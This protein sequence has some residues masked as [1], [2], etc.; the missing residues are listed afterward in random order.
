MIALV[1]VKAPDVAV[2]VLVQVLETFAAV[3]TPALLTVAQE[4][5]DEVQEAF[6]VRVWVLPSSKLPVAVKDCVCPLVIVR[7]EGVTV[8]EVSCGFT[9]NPRQPAAS[10]NITSARTR[11]AH[12][13]LRIL[14]DSIRI[15]N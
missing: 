10:I 13:P 9:K 4:V 7:L 1:A 14:V 6:P 15:P 2:I 5:S 3:T 11:L 8:R 12:C